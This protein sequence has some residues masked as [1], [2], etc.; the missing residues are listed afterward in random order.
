MPKYRLLTHEELQE[1]EKE[2][3]DYLI[4]NGITADDWQNLKDK[5][6]KKALEVVGL[7]SDV[8]FEGTMRQVQ[9]MEARM[10]KEVQTFQCL[11]NKLV[12]MAMRVGKDNAVDFTQPD[13]LEQAMANPPE[14]I[15]VYSME[16]EYTDQR[17]LELFKMTEMGCTISDGQLFKSLSMALAESKSV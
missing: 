6:S 10:P 7:F 1:F 8:I 16:K 11:D 5:D 17:E 14:D 15:E 9:F 13:S 12:M 3:I 4:V 2:F